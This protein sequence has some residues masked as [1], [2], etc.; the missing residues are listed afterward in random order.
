MVVKIFEA[1]CHLDEYEDIKKVWCY[2]HISCFDI[3][4][5]LKSAFN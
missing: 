2:I 5:T 3:A 4:S 1:I